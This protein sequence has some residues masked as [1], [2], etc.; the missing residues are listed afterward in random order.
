MKWTIMILILAAL[1]CL[2]FQYSDASPD[3]QMGQWTP[4][5][6]RKRA[7]ENTDASSAEE[8]DGSSFS[9][10]KSKIKPLAKKIGLNTLKSLL[11]TVIEKKVDYILKPFYQ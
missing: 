7:V 6:R 2:T 1:M 4:Y 5:G 11:K 3:T 9:K 10:I 8:K